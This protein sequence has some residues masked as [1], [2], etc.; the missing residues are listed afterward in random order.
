MKRKSPIRRAVRTAGI[1][2]AVISFLSS[3]LV[4][5]G[6][7]V[8]LIA[9]IMGGGGY[10][11]AVTP[12][13]YDC[14]ANPTAAPPPASPTAPTTK[15]APGTSTPTPTVST[16]SA[17]PYAL[18][19]SSGTTGLEETVNARGQV[20][21][22]GRPV[23]WAHFATLGAD[24]Q[25]YYL[26]MRWSY[27]SWNFNGT[28]G[29]D[30]EQTEFNWFDKGHQGKPWIVTVTNPRTGLSVNLAVIES[31]PAPWV[32]ITDSQHSANSDA[33]RFGWTNPTRGTPAG[34]KGIVAGMP[35]AAITT[36]GA[37]TGYP[38]NAGDVLNYSWA[39]D[40]NSVPGPTGA[41]AAAPPPGDSPVSGCSS[42]T[43]GTDCT[44]TGTYAGLGAD[45]QHNAQQIAQVALQR[46]FGIAGV[47]IG[48]MTAFTES[49]LMLVDHGDAMGPSSRG[50]FQQMPSWGPESVRMDAAGSAG[51]FYDRLSRISDWQTQKPWDV[52]QQVQGSEFDGKT[53][54]DGK[55][56]VY[57]SNY[58][59]NYALAVDI[60]NSILNRSATSRT[61]V[62]MSVPGS[63]ASPSG[64]AI[65]N[66]SQWCATSADPGGVTVNGV[67]VTLPTNPNVDAAVA[68]KVITAPNAAVA[69]G[70]AAGFAV[71]G[72][73]Y[74][75][76]GGTNGGS[77]DEGCARAG[78]QENSCQGI[79]GLDCSGLTGY[80]LAQ[81][82]FHIP[83]NS[84][85]QRAAGATVPWSQGKPG[86]IIGFPG[87]VAM[88]LGAIL[89]TGTIYILEAPDVGKQIRIVAMFRHDQDNVLHRYWS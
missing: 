38:G 47:V 22:T 69:R 27:A 50:L 52:A 20:P 5:I 85:A 31:G 28:N 77:P 61:L 17:I 25:N 64:T 44:V 78:G 51:L 23:T 2:A 45:Q 9:V 10:G 70:L 3:P 83:D 6:I 16:L 55:V 41:A 13:G 59:Q 29:K 7:A 48:V 76:G 21:S 72:I 71:I 73:P 14:T 86:D 1:C 4:I 89:G 33:A 37:T 80:V 15:A 82:G 67:A 57:G 36:L 46:G 42:V 66:T 62:A 84:S 18:P 88:Y 43:V 65:T 87:H 60:T 54:R 35:Q 56:L 40:Q 53:V 58:Q 74:V 49:N 8:L 39:V 63:P 81:A 11:T 68:G 79:I 26:A 19:A 24:Y 32:G 12:T 34:W 30:I 75:Y